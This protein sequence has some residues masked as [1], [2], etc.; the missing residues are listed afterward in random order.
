MLCIGD[1]VYGGSGEGPLS[2]KQV[3]SGCLI[4]S[5]DPLKFDAVC[6]S[7]MGFDYKRIPTI[8]NLW[9]GAE[10]TI[11][12]NDTCINGKELGDMQGRYKPANGWELLE[13]MD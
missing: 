12:S 13:N 5:D 6:A 3:K 4:V 1:M 8:K 11:S 7:L 10:I 9:G 2:P